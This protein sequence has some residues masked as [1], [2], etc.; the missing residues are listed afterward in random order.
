VGRRVGVVGADDDLQLRQDLGGFVLGVADHVQRA[1]A[2]AVERE[3]LGEGGGDEEAQAGL[4]ELADDRAVFGDAVAEAL[5]GHVQEGHQVA[6]LHRG[7]DLFPLGGEM[8]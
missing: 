7:D 8:S 5:V 3:A 4:D 6:G 2:F 1:H